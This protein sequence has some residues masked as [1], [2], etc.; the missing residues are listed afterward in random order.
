MLEHVLLTRGMRERLEDLAPISE[1]GIKVDKSRVYYSGISQGGIFGATFMALTPDI[2][3]GHLGVPGMD[4]FTLLGRSQNFTELFVLLGQ[5]YPKASDQWIA[6]QAVQQLWNQTDPSTYYRHITQE[7]LPGNGPH[8]VIAAP[9]QG[10]YQ[11]SP[12]TIETMARSDIGFAIMSPYSRTREVPMAPTAEYPRVGS[13]IVNWDF[14]NAWPA[15]GNQP[16]ANDPAGDPHGKPRQRA[17]HNRQMVH[18]FDT[19]EVIDVCGGEVCGD[20]ND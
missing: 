9:A 8:T 7:P 1:R 18:F 20:R 11:V 10:D 5:G 19:G 2:T 12:L 3:R 13:A 14:G 4:Y 17:D 15:P 16:P 6:L